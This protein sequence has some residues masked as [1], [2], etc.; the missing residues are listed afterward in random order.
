MKMQYG[1]IE[2]GICARCGFKKSI[3]IKRGICN[4]CFYELKR[5]LGII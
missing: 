3:S 2:K 4:K 5:V 1:R